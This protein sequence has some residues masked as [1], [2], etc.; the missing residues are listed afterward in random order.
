MC[1][2]DRVQGWPFCSYFEISISDSIVN[3]FYCKNYAVWGKRSWAICFKEVIDYTPQEKAERIKQGK[4]PKAHFDCLECDEIKKEWDDI[5]EKG[6]KRFWPTWGTGGVKNDDCTHITWYKC[7]KRF[8]YVWGVSEVMCDKDKSKSNI[9]GHNINWKTNS[10]RWPMLHFIKN[11]KN[12][13][14][15]III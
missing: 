15:L 7:E 13:I 11:I 8:W 3:Y 9:F 2:E 5:I 10:N 14:K 4:H 6:S 12:K 1:R